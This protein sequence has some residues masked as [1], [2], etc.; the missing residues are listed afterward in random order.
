MSPN[1]DAIAG[2]RKHFLKHIWGM[3]I[4]PR[5]RHCTECTVLCGV[6]ADW[7]VPA[8]GTCL[9]AGDRYPELGLPHYRPD[10]MA[11]AAC[12]RKTYVIAPPDNTYGALLQVASKVLTYRMLLI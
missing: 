7:P 2:F 9:G 5:A 8:R 4:Y 12:N 11:H 1:Q 3:C 6:L 10:C